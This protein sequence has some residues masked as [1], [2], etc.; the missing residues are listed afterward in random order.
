MH[1]AR[2]GAIAARP[3]SSLSATRRR[4]QAHLP[5]AIDH[6]HAAARDFF[7]NSIARNNGYRVRVRGTLGFGSSAE[8]SALLRPISFRRAK[9]INRKGNSLARSIAGES[10]PHTGGHVF[11]TGTVKGPLSQLGLPASVDCCERGRRIPNLL[12]IAGLSIGRRWRI[13]WFETAFPSR[14]GVGR[15]GT[16]LR[17]SRFE[18]C[19]VL[20][21]PL[22]LLSK[23]LKVTRRFITDTAEQ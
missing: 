7:G 5:R 12:L 23:I 3:E 17:Y 2:R 8:Y 9:A 10:S 1:R 6:A 21:T 16:L 4:F 20:S 15:L 19:D 22:I 13:E 18:T 11:A 14:R